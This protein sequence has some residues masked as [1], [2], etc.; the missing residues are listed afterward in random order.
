M[1]TSGVNF[2]ANRPDPATA[3]TRRRRPPSPQRRDN[4][5]VETPM[6]A[7]PRAMPEDMVPFYYDRPRSKGGSPE[8]RREQ[9]IILRY[10][11][12]QQAADPDAKSRDIREAELLTSRL[13]D[14]E[15]QEGD[16]IPL[17]NATFTVDKN[18]VGGGAY[19]SVLTD[20]AGQLAPK[21][22]CR[23]TAMRAGATGAWQSGLNNLSA[24]M[25]SQGVQTA[26]P[27]LAAYLQSHDV[28]SMEVLGKSMG[29]ACAQQLAILL[30][31]VAHVE[32]T[33]LVTVCSVGAGQAINDVFKERVLQERRTPF[34]LWVIRSGGDAQGNDVD[35]I[36]VVGGV[37]LGFDSA[38]E[39]C[40][41][42]VCYIAKGE[43]T[44]T[45]PQTFNRF[46]LSGKLLMSFPGGHSRQ[47]TLDKYAY[48]SITER[49]E[50]DKQLSIGNDLEGWRAGLSS[51]LQW[52]SGNKFNPPSLS[53]FIGA[54]VP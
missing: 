33:R 50:V 7:T 16:I 14:R 44:P 9:E 4:Q 36:P 31:T 40:T 2:S 46:T 10:H 47:T 43:D 45:Q 29:G 28:S 15:L 24:E 52:G 35:Y 3:S 11:A 13:A 22:V 12:Q 27:D 6:A 25:A 30:E 38:P 23:G 5:G 53:D 54:Q 32:V 39:K 19:V 17:T 21:L 41:V 26:W 42:E 8:A 51:W 37:H 34:N 18:F 20:N 48:E 49:T 1:K